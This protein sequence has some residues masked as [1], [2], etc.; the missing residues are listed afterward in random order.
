MNFNVSL[1]SGLTLKDIFMRQS[2]IGIVVAATLCISSTA[3]ANPSFDTRS[4]AMGGIGAST[5]DYLTAPFHN[6]ALVAKFHESDDFGLLLPTVGFGVQGSKD[7]LNNLEDASD[8]LSDFTDNGQ[9]DSDKI[10][11]SLSALKNGSA[12]VNVGVGIAVAIPNDV[13]SVNLYSQAY[14]NAVLRT[15]IDDDDLI[16]SS[17]DDPNY[18][19]QS[20]VNAL[21]VLVTEVG[22]ALARAQKFNSGTLY[23]GVT[24]KVQKLEGVNYTANMSDYDGSDALDDTSDKTVFNMDIGAA[25]SFDNGF[26]LGLVGKNILSQDIKLKESKGLSG[27]YKL[28]G[29]YTASASY[30]NS[31]LTVGLDADINKTK[32]FDSLTGFN[33]VGISKDDDD[34]QFMGVGAEFNAWDWA[35]L[36]VG[37]KVDVQ[38]NLDDEITAGIGLVPFKVFHLDLS[39]SYAGDS[40]YGASIQT[41]FT[42]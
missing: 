2:K 24:P 32:N 28:N 31:W 29:V 12:T 38:N 30:A 6:P 37:Y 7:F 11:S 34:I 5:S 8:A 9:V 26:T 33:N 22:V 20:Q 40:Q 10:T 4:M 42:F 25:Y 13:V 16:A 35:Q 3:Y 27:T 39:G 36:R 15:D 19:P 18:E 21:G 23:Y 1:L 41:Y 14:L 17:Y